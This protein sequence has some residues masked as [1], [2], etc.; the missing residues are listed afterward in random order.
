MHGICYDIANPAAIRYVV[1][2]PEGQVRRE[3]SIPVEHG[4][5]IHDC[6]I[7]QRYAVILDLPVTFSMPAA[8]AGQ[9]FPYRWNE[10]HE[11]RVGLLP[12]EGGAEEII[13][14]P[15][16]PCYVFHVVNSYDAQDGKVTACSREARQGRIRSVAAWSAGSSIR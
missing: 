3:V 10:A 4:P 7:T 9:S 14:A 13:W 12:R 11:A 2:T 16:D 8:M 5:M 6:A 15:V 1:V